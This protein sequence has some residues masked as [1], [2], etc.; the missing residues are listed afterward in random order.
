[1]QTRANFGGKIIG[2]KYICDNQMDAFHG[3]EIS[4]YK[5]G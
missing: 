1:M 3:G 5:N 4:I 2:E